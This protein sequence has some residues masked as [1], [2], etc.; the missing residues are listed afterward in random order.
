MPAAAQH[1]NPQGDSYVSLQT[2]AVL[3]HGSGAV[4]RNLLGYLLMSEEGL[5]HCE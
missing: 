3:V 4:H 1:P 5:E 2:N